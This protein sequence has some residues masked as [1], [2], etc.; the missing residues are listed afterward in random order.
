MPGPL[1]GIVVLDLTHVLAGPFASMVLADLGAQVIKIEQPEIGDRSRASG[2]FINGESTYFMS[3]NRGKLGMTLDLSKAR[4]K[5]TFLQ[6][7]A[8]ADV[9]LENLV[10]G[11][12][13]R[14]GLD[15]EVIKQ[16]N[17]GI[18]YAAISGFGQSG[19]YSTKA[20]LD[21]VV[22]GMGGV[23]S[24][25]GE[26]E[27]PPIR[28]GV[29]QGDITAGLFAIIGILA[30]LEERNSSGLGQ[31]VDISMLDCQVAILE[32]AF[33][34]Y[35]T[36]G[37]VPKPLGTRHPVTS[38]FQAFQTSD[39]YMTIAL[40]DG[41][42]EK[43]PLL[44]S[45]LDL[46]DLIDDPRFDDGWTRTQNWAI[47]EPIL[48]RAL[49]K[50]TTQEWLTELE[51]LGIPCGPVNTIDKAALDPQLQHRGMIK[52]IRHPRLGSV[53][54]VDTPLKLS[55]TP[56]GAY[57]PS[58]DLGEHTVQVLRDM[59]GLNEKEITALREEGAI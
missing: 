49:R 12:L 24:I 23:L 7:V 35:F 25:T 37:D 50:K 27:G 18:I 1:N 58:P 51:P 20:A 39:G 41:R 10:P 15:Y 47:A 31:M 45:A 19:P 59:L 46:I 52:D 13:K 17:P 5:E 14:L 32:N 33:T 22:Q 28:P 38:P 30:A 43:W 8:K 56:G 2:P 55:R 44:C 16:H 40:A 53:K 21:V 4:G 11:A 26:P 54:I 42:K 34:R 6:M 3:I 9:I 29:S 48:A 57:L 36:T